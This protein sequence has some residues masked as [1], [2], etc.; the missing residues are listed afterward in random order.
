MCKRCG[1]DRYLFSRGRCKLCAQIEDGLGITKP[2]IKS[3]GG[4]EQDRWFQE[5]R[6]EMVGKCLNCG[7]PSCMHSDVYYKFSIAH[8]LPKSPRM[9]PSVATHP[10]NWIELCFWEND[11]HGRFDKFTLD[12][13]EMNCYDLIIERFLRMYPAIAPAE[14]RRIPDTLMQYVRNETDI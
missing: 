4:S 11:C 3:V 13:T 10:D 8:I 12:L 9:F 7:K 6:L 2:R 14:R 5:R 1:K